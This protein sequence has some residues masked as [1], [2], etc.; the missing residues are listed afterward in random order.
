M[1]LFEVGALDTHRNNDDFFRDA[2]TGAQPVIGSGQMVYW[3]NCTVTVFA[4]GKEDGQPIR[5]LSKCSGQ[6]SLKRG[7]SVLFEEGKVKEEE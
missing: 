6:A 4:S 5:R 2:K 3:Q 7:V 1:E